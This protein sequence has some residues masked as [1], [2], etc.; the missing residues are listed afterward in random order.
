MKKENTRGQKVPSFYTKM[1]KDKVKKLVNKGLEERQDLFL[2][3][4]KVS[5]DNAIMVIID[6]DNG[7]LVEDCMFISR[8][9]EHN[10]D[11]EE[12]DFSIEVTSAGATSPLINN[13]QYKKNIG[14]LLAVKTKDNQ[15]FEAKLTNCD[16]EGIFLEWKTKEPKPVGKGKIVVKKQA[17]IEFD[18]IL[19][20]QVVIKF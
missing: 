1:F 15:S 16:N 17:K 11:R 20:A 5:E 7:V 13:R 18:T 4:L 3:D 9:I 19:E 2:L 10:L 6:G 8:A 12:Q 14:R